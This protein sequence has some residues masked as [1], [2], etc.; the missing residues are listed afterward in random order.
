MAV[1]AV[2]FDIDGTLLTDARNVS[3]STITAINELKKAGILVGL[4]TGRGPRFLL[5]YM[6]ALGLDVAVAYNGQYILS[7]EKVL[8]TNPLAISDIQEMIE[9][10][11]QHQRDLSFGTAAGVVGSGLMS[12]GNGNLAYKITKLIPN[13]WAGF[14]TFLF[15]QILRRISPQKSGNL[16]DLLT[17]PIYQMMVITTQKES[18]KLEQRFEHLSFTRSSAYVADVISKGQ[19]KLAGIARVGDLY[20]FDTSEVMAFGDSDNDMEMLSGVGYAI[21]MGNGTKRLKKIATYVT[22]SNNKDGI[23]QAIKKFGLVKGGNDVSE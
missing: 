16:Q 6:A 14:V 9:Y 12:F 13:S 7:R 17:Q 20:G 23:F 1:K 2:F 19:S 8:F 15:N 21:A 4:A 5:Q 10:A 22:A 11:D 18:Q 3:Q